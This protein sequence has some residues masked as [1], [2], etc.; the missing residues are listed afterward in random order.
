MAVLEPALTMPNLGFSKRLKGKNCTPMACLLI[1][2]YSVQELFKIE[3]HMHSLGRCVCVTDTSED[4]LLKLVL[5][6][7]C[8]GA[9]DPTQVVRLGSKTLYEGN[10]LASVL[11]AEYMGV[12]LPLG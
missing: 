5:S 2:S 9:G 3:N 7:H 8:L 4:N 10:H 11:R 6:F 1:S 12:P